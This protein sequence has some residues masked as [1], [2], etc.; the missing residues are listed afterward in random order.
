MKAS[1]LDSKRKYINFNEL[2]SINEQLAADLEF[3]KLKQWRLR[4]ILLKTFPTLKYKLPSLFLFILYSFAAFFIIQYNHLPSLWMLL[5][6][7]IYLPLMFLAINTD[8]HKSKVIQMSWVCR[9]FSCGKCAFILYWI[10]SLPLE[11]KR[12]LIRLLSDPQKLSAATSYAHQKQ[13]YLQLCISSSVVQITL[14]LITIS[15]LF[16]TSQII[17]EFLVVSIFTTLL[18]SFLINAKYLLS[19]QTIIKT[20][21]KHR[22][23]WSEHLKSQ[24]HL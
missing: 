18:I 23:Q 4:N 3:F 8:W 10:N 20:L 9:L 17:R 21:N 13:T 16:S 6:F 12:L 2:K 5:L 14:L 24:I 22:T 11:N 7:A 15:A 1:A 19:F